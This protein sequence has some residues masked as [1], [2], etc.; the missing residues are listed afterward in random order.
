MSLFPILGWKY[1]MDSM[2]LALKLCPVCGTVAT[3]IL[4]LMIWF[5]KHVGLSGKKKL[6]RPVSGSLGLRTIHGGEWSYVLMRAWAGQAKRSWWWRDTGSAWSPGFII[7]LY[8]TDHFQCGTIPPFAPPIIKSCVIWKDISPG[9]PLHVY[10][11]SPK[12]SNL[13]PHIRLW[14]NIRRYTPVICH[15]QPYPQPLSALPASLPWRPASDT[16]SRFTSD[17]SIRGNLRWLLRVSH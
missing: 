15:H 10:S 13:N 4:G 12:R 3:L 17:A 16:S 7:K 5:Q 8:P 6:S 14:A 11:G 2:I 9:M 1:E